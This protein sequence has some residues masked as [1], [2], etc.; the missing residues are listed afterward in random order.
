MHDTPHSL[1]K[2]PR[3]P[4]QIIVAGP[5]SAPKGKRATGKSPGSL[6]TEKPL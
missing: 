2:T 5:Y 6:R 4:L 1:H 3:M